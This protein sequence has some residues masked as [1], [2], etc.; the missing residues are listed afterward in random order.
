ML[1]QKVLLVAINKVIGGKIKLFKK[2][3]YGINFYKW[4]TLPITKNF[5]LL[6]L[7]AT[8]FEHQISD[9]SKKFQS[10]KVSK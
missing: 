10:C 1:N 4:A 9:K 2:W 6:N 3:D 7:G 8:N 5:G